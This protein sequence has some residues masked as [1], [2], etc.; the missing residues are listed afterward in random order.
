[1]RNPSLH[2][3]IMYLISAPSPPLLAEDIQGDHGDHSQE[4]CGGMQNSGSETQSQGGSPNSVC[5]LQIRVQPEAQDSM[6]MHWP[7]PCMPL[8]YQSCR[9]PPDKSLPL[10]KE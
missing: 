8:A 7:R 2:S 9:Q 5:D 4:I 3:E 10:H 1:M 6:H